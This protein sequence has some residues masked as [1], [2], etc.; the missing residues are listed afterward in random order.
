MKPHP[1]GVGPKG[2]KLRFA[3]PR[4]ILIRVVDHEHRAMG[5]GHTRRADRTEQQPS[6]TPMSAASNHDH[7]RFAAGLNQT[8]PGM[9]PDKAGDN[10]VRK[11]GPERL[12]DSLAKD[13]SCGFLEVRYAH[14]HVA[15]VNTRILPKCCGYH[16]G[17]QGPGELLGHAE[18]SDGCLGAVNSNDDLSRRILAVHD[19]PFA[20]PTF[21]SAA[22][23]P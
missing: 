23:Y 18:S 11:R 2:P 13:L 16:L 15:V 17:A 10:V 8:L 6:E 22:K 12:F 3:L 14:G 7:V 4:C 21:L 20:E 1:G 19:R 5:M 9:I